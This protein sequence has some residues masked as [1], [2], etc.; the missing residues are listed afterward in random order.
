MRFGA[1]FSSWTGFELALTGVA[2]VASDSRR[3]PA[4]KKRLGFSVVFLFSCG[5]TRTLFDQ[6]KVSVKLSLPLF[7][8]R[9]P[10]RSYRT[11]RSAGRRR[12][13]ANWCA[14]RKNIGMR[15]PCRCVLTSWR[16]GGAAVE[17]YGWF[18]WL[19]LCLLQIGIQLPSPAVLLDFFF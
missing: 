15:S 2:A 19:K 1:I 6:K 17:V 16:W 3:K 7:E 10:S 5:E 14:K 12:S 11:A 9:R 18:C 8:V 4:K 13:W